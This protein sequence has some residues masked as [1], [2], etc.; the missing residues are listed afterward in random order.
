MEAASKRAK[1]VSDSIKDFKEMDNL[2][3][4]I[5]Q[6]REMGNDLPGC[7]SSNGGIT[8]DDLWF[9]PNC[10]GTTNDSGTAYFRVDPYS[11]GINCNNYKLRFR[12]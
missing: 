11:A 9:S 1:L 10:S 7:C 4:V 3:I 12:F 5:D 8:I 6:A 2:Q